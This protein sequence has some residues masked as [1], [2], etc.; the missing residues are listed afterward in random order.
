MRLDMKKY[1]ISAI[2][3]IQTGYANLDSDALFWGDA[4]HHVYIRTLGGYVP[5]GLNTSEY[6]SFCFA[7][8]P[9]EPSTSDTVQ[10]P[11]S[12]TSSNRGFK[13]KGQDI[14]DLEVEVSF[15]KNDD[16]REIPLSSETK[17]NREQNPLTRKS[18]RLLKK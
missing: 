11:K 18:P 4:S 13:R 17:E 10:D 3:F 5:V 2:L 12:C 15:D 9:K 7:Y 14:I 8:R 1:F 6:W 16:S